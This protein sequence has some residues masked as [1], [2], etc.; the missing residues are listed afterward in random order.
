MSNTLHAGQASAQETVKDLLCHLQLVPLYLEPAA[1]HQTNSCVQATYNGTGQP[2]VGEV[3]SSYGL[4]FTGANCSQNLKSYGASGVGV[5]P[6]SK[7]NGTI[8]SVT[9]VAPENLP[10]TA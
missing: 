6:A 4:S 1:L 2:A 10:G 5:G 8:A 7:F 3:W 9:G